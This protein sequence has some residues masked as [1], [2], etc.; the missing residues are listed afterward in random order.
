MK[1]ATKRVAAPRNSTQPRLASETTHTAVRAKDHS[2]LRFQASSLQN[3]TGNGSRIEIIS[4]HRK[5]RR[6]THSN[7]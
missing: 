4:T 5:Q 3:L 7:R 6:A 2:S 1:R